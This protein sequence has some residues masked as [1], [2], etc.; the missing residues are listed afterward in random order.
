MMAA[1][2]GTRL[3]HGMVMVADG[4]IGTG[5]LASGASVHDLPLLPLQS[6]DSVFQLHLRY[7]EAGSQII[8]THTFQANASKL[9]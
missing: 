1:E 5:L 7:L 2:L 4:A 9:A 6:P 8:E 3:R